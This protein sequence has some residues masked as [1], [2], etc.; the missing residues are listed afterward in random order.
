MGD[1]L[2]QLFLGRAD[3]AVGEVEP[4]AG[5]RVG[6]DARERR[7]EERTLLRQVEAGRSGG[8]RLA[9]DR[10]GVLLESVAAAARAVDLA[11]PGVEDEVEL[12]R[13]RKRRRGDREGADRDEGDVERSG[14]AARERRPGPEPGE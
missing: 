9:R 13:L 11:A 10:P 1:E 6:G 3:P 2:C 14:E 12:R 7:G 8:R 5:G 4:G